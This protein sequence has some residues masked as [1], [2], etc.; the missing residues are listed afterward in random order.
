MKGNLLKICVFAMLCLM[1]STY[2]SAA[3]TTVANTDE[4]KQIVT[5]SRDSVRF[6]GELT[7]QEALNDKFIAFDDNGYVLIHYN[8]WSTFTPLE[9]G[10][11]VA[12]DT[13]V[14]FQNNQS[15]VATLLLNKDYMISKVRKVSAGAELRE[16]VEATVAGIKDVDAYNLEYVKLSDVS[17]FKKDMG[18]KQEHYIISGNDTIMMTNETGD[19]VFPSKMN[20]SGYTWRSN[21]V[22]VFYFVNANGIEATEI[23]NLAVLRDSKAVE[24]VNLV[25]AK[26]L[27]TSRKPLAKGNL[28]RMQ[29][30]DYQPFG[31]QFVDTANVLD[32]N[33]GDSVA[34]SGEVDYT[35]FSF[36]EDDGVWDSAVPALMFVSKGSA[37]TA[38]RLSGGNRPLYYSYSLYE[39]ADLFKYAQNAVITVNN[40]GVFFSTEELIEKGFVGLAIADNS[41]KYDTVLVDAQY[42]VEANSPTTG[43][44]S[45]HLLQDYNERGEYYY[46]IVPRSA[47]DFIADT[48][49][50]SSIADMI[51]SGTPEIF[52][53]LYRYT[54][55][56]T[57]TAKI[58]VTVG[59]DDF[60]YVFIED[61]TGA[62]YINSGKTDN[63]KFGVGQT[64]TNICGRFNGVVP[65]RETNPAE[66]AYMELLMGDGI[67]EV[68]PAVEIVAD[69]VDVA[70]LIDGS[71]DNASNLV[72]LKN[73]MIKQSAE[74][75]GVVYYAVQGEDT[76]P[77]NSMVDDIEYPL[78]TVVG[79]LVGVVFQNQYNS[80]RLVVRSQDDVQKEYKD[81]DDKPEVAV[82]L[83]E[84]DTNVYVADGILV[85]ENAQICLV[86]LAGRIVATGV[87]SIDMNNLSKQVYLAITM[88]GDGRNYVTKVVL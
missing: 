88:Y 36:I 5:T 17:Y 43:M 2:L 41:A 19:I 82:E 14:L 11:V 49:V 79:A 70:A 56:A 81:D 30:G 35:P 68:T 45:G 72:R 52:T 1:T 12:I 53:V 66:P 10:D 28:Y 22:A 77:I 78:D 51:E 47:A 50:F 54:G 15:N 76:V 83:V 21:K 69:D 64:I 34:L 74:E 23:D 26:M 84:T 87:N 58:V 80:T 46:A 59:D 37:V 18:W 63:V 9:V 7:V 67:A 6:T 24:G 62:L 31:V 25:G 29:F 13:I 4:L 40:S 61:E 32:V 8:V 20:I 16:P 44:V 60:N 33:E 71:I 39:A 65:A 73:V 57:I 85:A 42:F 86:D 48:V 75:D 55:A 3:V 38:T 27:V